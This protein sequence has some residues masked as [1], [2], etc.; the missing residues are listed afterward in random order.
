MI[1]SGCLAKLNNKRFNN[2][3]LKLNLRDLGLYY[4]LI[5]FFIKA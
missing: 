4:I 2:I 1:G 5:F 3:N